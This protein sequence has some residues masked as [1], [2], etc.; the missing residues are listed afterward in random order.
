MKLKDLKTW[1]PRAALLYGVAAYATIG[2]Y[3]YLKLHPPGREK[4]DSENT[5]KYKEDTHVTSVLGFQVTSTVRYKEN[6][7]PYSTRL[8]NYL[9]NLVGSSESSVGTQ[10]DEK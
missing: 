7:V 8:F 4:D 1:N 9:T 3:G 6:F 2:I 5:P 10:G